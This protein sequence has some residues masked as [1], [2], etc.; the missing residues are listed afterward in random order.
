MHTLLMQLEK[1]G[2]GLFVVALCAL[3]QAAFEIISAILAAQR[4][5]VSGK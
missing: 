4:N 5:Q 3:N 2:K 1:C